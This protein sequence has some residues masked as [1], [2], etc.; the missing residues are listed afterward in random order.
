MRRAIPAALICAA[1][2]GCASR[3]VVKPDELRKITGYTSTSGETGGGEGKLEDAQGTRFTL[4]KHTRFRIKLK[5]E[6][7]VAGELTA[8]ATQGDLLMVVTEGGDELALPFDEIDSAKIVVKKNPLGATFSVI[9]VTLY[10]LLSTVIVG[11]A[12][13]YVI[14]I[15]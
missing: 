3:Y 10:G 5:K 2:S 11:A 15:I 1:L 12:V 6:A 13:G 7:T 4:K 14:L 8:V 9:G